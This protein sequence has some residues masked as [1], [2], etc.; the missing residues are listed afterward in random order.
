MRSFKTQQSTH[1]QS[2]HLKSTYECSMKTEVELIWVEYM[3]LLPRPRQHRD[4]REFM[5]Y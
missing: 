3:D 2:T 1:L 5:K 4:M